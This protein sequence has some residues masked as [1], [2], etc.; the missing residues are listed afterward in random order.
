MY[1]LNLLNNL[2]NKQ[3]GICPVCGE[4]IN[5]FD[6]YDWQIHRI[7]PKE[8]LNAFPEYTETEDNLLLIHPD[9]ITHTDLNGAK[10]ICY[11][12]LILPVHVKET[13]LD[14]C[15]EYMSRWPEMF[16]IFKYLMDFKNH[17]C[18]MCG[19]E[20][21]MFESYPIDYSLNFIETIDKAM[22]LCEECYS[23]SRILIT[24]PKYSPY[25]TRRNLAII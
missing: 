6:V 13:V 7:M 17:K 22:L 16:P 23:R 4:I 15:D 2:Y 8:F 12:Q 14:L 19:K 25:W 11:N 20:V 21:H 10:P 5:P 3:M 1:N 18:D 9:C 24:P